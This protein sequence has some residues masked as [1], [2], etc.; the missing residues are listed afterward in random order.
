MADERRAAIDLEAIED[1]PLASLS[2]V[3]FLSALSGAGTIGVQAMRF[4]PEKKKYELY[5][6]PEN[7]GKTTIGGLFKGVREKK[8]VELE[9]DLRTE[10]VHKL[11]GSEIE[12]L[13]PQDLVINPAFREAVTVIAREVVN[14][15]GRR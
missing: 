2:A 14:Q 7:L 15:L 1:K 8:K 10:L 11:P 9:K 12:V 4:W 5:S 6:E 13:N 3:D